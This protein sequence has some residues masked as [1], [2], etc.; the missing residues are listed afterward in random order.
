MATDIMAMRGRR[1]S[2]LRMGASS[3][4]R[5]EEPEDND[6]YRDASGRY[7][8]YYAHLMGYAPNV[9]EGLAVREGDVIG[10]VGRREMRPE[11]RPIFTFR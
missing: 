11:V 2:P 5:M 4:W 3:N 9:I 1:F 6:L 8:H 7:F 10:F